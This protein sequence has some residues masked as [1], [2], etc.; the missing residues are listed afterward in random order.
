MV[1][2]LSI[3]INAINPTYG[4]TSFSTYNGLNQQYITPLNYAAEIEVTVLLGIDG[5]TTDEQLY[6]LTFG[7]GIWYENIVIIDKGYRYFSAST[8]S[9]ELSFYCT[10]RL[11]FTIDVPYDSYFSLTEIVEKKDID[12]H[13]SFGYGV[14]VEKIHLVPYS[15]PAYVGGLDDTEYTLYFTTNFFDYYFDGFTDIENVYPYVY[16]STNYGS[17]SQ[18]VYGDST[19]VNAI[20][21]DNRFLKLTYSFSRSFMR[22][23]SFTMENRIHYTMNY[24]SYDVYHYIRA[25]RPEL[26]EFYVYLSVYYNSNDGVYIVNNDT[27]STGDIDVSSLYQPIK[28]NTDQGIIDFLTSIFTV[29]LPNV[30]NNFIVWFMCEAPLVSKITKPFFLL[31]VQTANI[32]LQWI[33]PLVTATGIFGSILLCILLIRLFK[34]LLK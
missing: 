30:V 4:Y 10:Y 23:K 27:S 17:S 22:I 21:L 34:G 15:P 7:N 9:D 31:A 28:V 11:T 8:G 25:D 29:V 14:R 1:M 2:I 16:I 32:T 6:L 12:L 18:I 26:S 20:N 5:E 3:P 24:N 13:P 19:N 33:L